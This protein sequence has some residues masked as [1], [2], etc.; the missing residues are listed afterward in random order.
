MGWDGVRGQRV[1]TSTQSTLPPSSP[2]KARFSLM[3]NSRKK[4]TTKQC[5]FRICDRI[6]APSFFYICLFNGDLDLEYILYD[7]HHHRHHRDNYRYAGYER[8]VGD[9]GCCY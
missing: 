6:S 8:C 2:A 3:M 7:I 9:G 1:V 4:E 5:C